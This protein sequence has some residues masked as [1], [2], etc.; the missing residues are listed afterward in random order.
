MICRLHPI[1]L[2]LSLEYA[3]LG[4]VY[5][6]CSDGSK[7]LQFEQIV[8]WAT[9]I[10]KGIIFTIYTFYTVAQLVR[11]QHRKRRAVDK[12]AKL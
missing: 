2:V 10:S 12:K 1:L 5:S 6:Y 8:K 3:S 7:E 11:V 4:S 9:D